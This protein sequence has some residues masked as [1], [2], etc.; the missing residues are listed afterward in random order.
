M[1]GYT[2]M[3]LPDKDLEKIHT[4]RI[5]IAATQEKMA[6]E[7]ETMWYISTATLR[8]P[9]GRDWTDIFMYLTRKYM[10][11][12]KI[13]PHDFLE[14]QIVLNELQESDLRNLRGWL[15]KRSME[16]VKRKAK[17]L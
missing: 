8:A 10:K 7:A 1:P 15:F 13:D 6:S 9:I 16:E 14:N 2:D 3:S 5:I 17:N 11:G 12:L 4:E